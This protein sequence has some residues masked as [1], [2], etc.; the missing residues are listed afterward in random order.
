MSPNKNNQNGACRLRALFKTQHHRVNKK[1]RWILR[2]LACYHKKNNRY[3][4][5]FLNPKNQNK[6]LFYFFIHSDSALCKSQQTKQDKP[7]FIL[8]RE[9]VKKKKEIKLKNFV[10][11]IRQFA[12]VNKKKEAAAQV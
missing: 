11:K 5:N 4:P 2:I 7:K 6:F 12:C 3:V 8:K 10:T 1:V 9:V